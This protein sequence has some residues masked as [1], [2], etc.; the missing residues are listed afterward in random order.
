[1]NLHDWL[2]E[3]HYRPSTARATLRHID[4]A[5]GLEELPDYMLPALR[6]YLAW[7]ESVGEETALQTEPDG[8]ELYRKVCDLDL[9]PSRGKGHQ[10]KTRKKERRSFDDE[11][12]QMLVT[13][14][15][16]KN[17]R[18][19]VV[20]TA[21]LG[22]LRISDVLPLTLPQVQAGTEKGIIRM[23]RK[24]GKMVDVATRPE[25]WTP[26]AI[27]MQARESPTVAAYLTGQ[28][29]ASTM[30]ADAA[31]QRVRRALITIGN[32][33]ALTGPVHLHRLRRTRAVQALR[34]TKD[35]TL[36]QGLL[37][38]SSIRSTYHYVDESRTEDVSRL[39][40]KMAGFDKPREKKGT[41]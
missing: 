24:G 7:I 3:N 5:R 35:L 34:I 18:E 16:G 28:D 10:P 41:D 20:L 8:G 6:R 11:S 32:E 26:L 9:E 19:G 37:G 21:M 4:S 33:L 39:Q 38:H 2:I 29:D 31:Y 15:R 22:G 14:I 1:M 23:E 13:T 40:R 27:G 17:T 30:S 12:W 25:D 36:V